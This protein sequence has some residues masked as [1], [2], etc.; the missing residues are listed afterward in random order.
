MNLAARV[1]LGL[2]VSSDYPKQEP[3]HTVARNLDLLWFLIPIAGFLLF[4]ETI[5]ARYAD[6]QVGPGI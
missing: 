1:Y 2:L 4:L 3:A 5:K 6:R